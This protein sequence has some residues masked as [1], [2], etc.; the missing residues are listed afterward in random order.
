MGF[1]TVIDPDTGEEKEVW[2]RAG[3]GDKELYEEQ[4]TDK[5]AIADLATS[6]SAKEAIV[7]TGQAI[8]RMFVNAGINA[9]QEGSDTIRDIGG[10]LGYGEGTS[11][12]E[13]DKPIIGLGGWRPEPLESEGAIED[14]GTGILQFGLEWMLLSKVLKGANWGLKGLAKAPVVGKAFK[15]ISKGVTK[16]QKTTKGIEVGAAKAASKIPV[17]GKLAAPVA[18]SAVNATL[19]PKGMIVDFAGFDQYEGRLYDLAANTPA[20]QFI[21]D[22]ANPWLREL[23]GQLKSDPT[24]SA[25]VG[26]LKNA[27]EGWGIDFGVGTTAS[28]VRLLQGKWAIENLAK[29]VPGTPEFYK[30][31]DDVKTIEA[32]NAKDPVILSH[33]QKIARADR[34]VFDKAMA[35][36]PPNKRALLWKE[37]REKSGKIVDKQGVKT[38]SG[39]LDSV[40]R[41]IQELGPEPKKPKPFYEMVDGKRRMTPEAKVWN[42]WNRTNKPLQE[43]LE[44]LAGK[45][46]GEVQITEREKFIAK[47]METGDIPIDDE[48]LKMVQDGDSYEQIIKRVTSRKPKPFAGIHEDPR[49][50]SKARG[51]EKIKQRLMKKFPADGLDIDEAEAIEEF[52]DVIGHHMFDDVAISIRN[53]IGDKKGE[54]NFLDNLVSI[55]KKVIEEGEFERTVVHELWHSL[56]RFLPEKDLARYRK[57]FI[58]ERTKYLKEWEKKKKAWIKEMTPEKL[59]S[60]MQVED[61][62]TGRMTKVKKITEKNFVEEAS[63]Y[64]DKAKFKSEADYRYTNM[65]EYFAEN[66]TDAFFAKLDEGLIQGLKGRAPGSQFIQ[67]DTFKGLIY[68]IGVYFQ[69]LIASIHARLGG[70][71]TKKIFN[72]FL[73]QRNT[74]LERDHPLHWS[75]EAAA[76]FELQKKTGQAQIAAVT[77]Q[78]KIIRES[79][80]VPEDFV[81]AK[82]E[83]IADDFLEQLKKVDEGEI[84]IDDPN[85]WRDQDVGAIRKRSKAFTDANPEEKIYVDTSPEVEML[86]DS[87]SRKID[88]IA[89]TGL[90]VLQNKRTV[91]RLLESFREEGFPLTEFIDSDGFKRASQFMSNNVETVRQLLTLR[92]GLDVTARNTAKLARQVRNVQVNNLGQFDEIMQELHKS[93]EKSLRYSSEYRKWTRAAAQQLQSTQTRIDTSGIEITD[94]QIKVNVD[95][96]QAKEGLKESVQPGDSFKNL[97]DSYRDAVENGNWTPEAEAIAWELSGHAM[98]ID[99]GVRTVEKYIGGPSPISRAPKKIDAEERIGKGFATWRV[100]QML[101]AMKTWGVQASAFVRMAGEPL[102]MGAIEAGSGNLHR[103]NMAMQQYR[104]IMR[105]VR[106]ALQ[107]AEA[108]LESGVAL[109]DPKRRAGAWIGDVIEDSYQQGRAFQIEESH[110]A[111]NLNQFP[112]LKEAKDNPYHRALNVLWKAGTLDI[113]GQQALETFQK[114][115]MGNSLL[116]TIGLEE[117]L[118]QAGRIIDE[119]TGK[120]LTREQQWEYAERWAQAKVDFYTSDAVVNG[121]TIQDAIMNDETALAI[122]RI[123]TFTN[124]IRAR[125]PKRTYAFGE[126]LARERGI[127]E[128]QDID[129]FAL[130]YRDGK[131]NNPVLK[132]YNRTMRV[133]GA[134]SNRLGDKNLKAGQ[135]FAD[136]PEVG[137]VTPTL[138]GVWSAIPQFWSGL[139]SS[140]RGYI[141]SAIQPFNR[142][143]GDMTK[144]WLR[145]TPLAPTVDTFYRDLF[146]ESGKIS[147]RW[148]GEL[149]IGSLVSTAFVGGVLFNDDF[150]IE[151]TGFG[152]QGADMRNMWDQAG[153]RP[154]SWRHKW[155]DDDGNWHYGQWRSYR[156]F[157]PAT[158]LIAGLADYK[159]LYSELNQQ[160]RDNFGAAL[161]I[162]LAAQVI[163]GRFQSSYYQGISS[164]INTF[165]PSPWGRRELEPGERGRFARGVQ[166][167]LLGFVPR[168]SHLREMRQAFDPAKR[169]VYDEGIEPTVTVD[170]NEIDEL[171]QSDITFGKD[172]SGLDIPYIRPENMPEGDIAQALHNAS[173]FSTQISHELQNILPGFSNDLPIRTNWITGEPLLNP[174]FLGSDQIPGDDAPWLYRLGVSGA[175]SVPGNLLGEFGIGTKSPKTKSGYPPMT[176]K[177]VVLMEEM[178]KISQAGQ[179][180]PPP[181]PTDMGKNIE[182]SHQAF[183]QYKMYIHTITLDEYQVKDPD[184]TIRPA[185]LAEALHWTITKDP[186][187]TGLGYINHPIGPNDTKK[188]YVKKQILDEIITKYK[189]A[190]K[191]EF[192]NDPNNPYRMEVTVIEQQREHNKL[193]FQ[194]LKDGGPHPDQM[195]FQDQSVNMNKEDLNAQQFVAQLNR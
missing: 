21:E 7:K 28:M 149:A 8:P 181:R 147:N 183:K 51:A 91:E 102:M 162:S 146:H 62:M 141:A 104:Y 92:I 145:H 127:T 20:F 64:F 131:V 66:L 117:G 164:F 118:A 133:G 177:N 185:N 169:F 23:L 124:D 69:D 156:A 171:N 29:Q 105:Y 160:Q 30:A 13:P 192:V 116:H 41:Q 159:M 58:R 195:K 44:E 151:F 38:I 33:A 99:N 161:T 176:K 125:I 48:V 78:G 186:R 47:G 67:T 37:L 153:R 60:K 61:W 22:N 70:P 14:L 72:D 68:R 165:S 184:G 140:K 3:K 76:E 158:T 59:Q 5:A 93:L 152:P 31:V 143:P 170:W 1:T 150:P 10:A 108:S 167:F 182:L 142:S 24:D 45:Q 179:A 26:R 132:A 2:Q 77:E 63:K 103:A 49:G 154:L 88:R 111:Y 128:P 129:K 136:V 18:A 122:G 39:D 83:E 90:P 106:G 4:V 157:E 85:L 193:E 94:T 95:A 86:F 120:P 163:Q 98:D 42:K 80:F 25:L 139:Q 19:N 173:T 53:S 84:D 134:I 110:P 172:G 148:K 137:E 43:R 101:S 56:S 190:A 27:I 89:D 175:L 187:Y 97:P 71:Q 11:A 191:E 35:H 180:F 54:F 81:V 144:Q 52:I 123:L 100:S 155:R 6:L 87:I 107:L 79:Q 73:Q 50:L 113:R 32:K 17:V 16:I 135:S 55:R 65:D 46:V 121:V 82:E 15:P 12:E 188:G 74:I 178:L 130:E 194:L 9:V 36:I 138:T 109:Y 126:Q 168:S 112:F 34:A 189:N 119:T 114:S 96:D 166:R 75:D 57:E 174:G 115:L 40:R